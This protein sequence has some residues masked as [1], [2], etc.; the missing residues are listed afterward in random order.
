MLS[1]PLALALKALTGVTM[2]VWSPLIVPVL[3]ITDRPETQVAALHARG[4]QRSRLVLVLDIARRL[5]S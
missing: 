3:A 2:K 4:G 5:S 1:L